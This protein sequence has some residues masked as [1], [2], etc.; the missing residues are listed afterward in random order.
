MPVTDHV[1]PDGATRRKIEALADG[2]TKL[3]TLPPKKIVAYATAIILGVDRREALLEA[4]Y[5]KNWRTP[6]AG[7]NVPVVERSVDDIVLRLDEKAKRLLAV[8]K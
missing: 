8:A 1:A 2:L 3:D 4:T 6:A 5:G 7:W